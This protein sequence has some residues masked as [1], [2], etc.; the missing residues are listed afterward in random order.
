MVLCTLGADDGRL[1][2]PFR[3]RKELDNAHGWAEL[4][5][6]VDVEALLVRQTRRRR[7]YDRCGAEDRRSDQV[8]GGEHDAA[9]TFHERRRHTRGARARRVWR[10]RAGSKV[11]E[12]FVCGWHAVE[13]QGGQVGVA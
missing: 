4:D 11:G 8:V 13:R 2:S 9:R 6:G 1:C 12:V 7:R 3:T 5:P 10:R